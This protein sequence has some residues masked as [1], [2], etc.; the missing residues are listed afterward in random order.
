MVDTEDT[1]HMTDDV[2]RISDNARG[3]AKAPHR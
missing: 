1:G 2:R 3:M